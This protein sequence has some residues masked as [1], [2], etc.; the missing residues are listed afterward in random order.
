MFSQFPMQQFAKAWQRGH[1]SAFVPKKYGGKS[2][3]KQL[4]E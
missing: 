4:T 1:A 3:S 2:A